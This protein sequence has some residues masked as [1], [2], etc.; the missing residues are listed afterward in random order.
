VTRTRIG[1]RPSSVAFTGAGVW[2]ADDFGVS[3]LEPETGQIQTSVSVG[4]VALVAGFGERVLIASFASDRVAEVDAESAEILWEIEVTSPRAIVLDATTSWVASENPHR[5]T[6]LA[7]EGEVTGTVHLAGSPRALV[8]VDGDPWVA[9]DSEIAVVDGDSLVPHAI[10]LGTGIEV[11]SMTAHGSVW[12]TFHEMPMGGGAMRFDPETLEHESVTVSARAMKL[13]VF[14][15]ISDGDV[16]WLTAG[17]GGGLGDTQTQ[18]RLSAVDPESLAVGPEYRLPPAAIV[19]GVHQNRLWSASQLDELL[20]LTPGEEAE[21]PPA[22]AAGSVGGL[23]IEVDVAYTSPLDCGAVTECEALAHVIAP[24][25]S[26]S[27]LPTFVLYLGQPGQIEAR[28]WLVPLAAAL[29]DRGAVSYVAAYGRPDAREEM[30]CAVRFARETTAGYGGDPQRIILM[31]GSWSAG[32]AIEMATSADVSSD[33][34]VAAGSGIPNAAVW[35]AGGGR[36]T[37]SPDFDVP[38]L[39]LISGSDDESAAFGPRFEE[40]LRSEGYDAT[41]V[42]LPGIDHFEVWG[43]SS[44]TGTVDALM[45]IAA[46]LEP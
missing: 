32:V 4:P 41:Y 45:D 23:R 37:P 8:L 35:I 5:L 25:A 3:L 46:E 15:A 24:A 36:A 39:R 31:G 28:R 33:D 30:R 34:C 44:Q 11:T 10:P 13:G 29:A 20:S 2:V 27:A 40:Q 9:L 42:E 22:T 7:S 12:V 21:Q 43:P 26:E 18:R 17:G 38:P 6:R 14:S 1:P 16:I 19:L